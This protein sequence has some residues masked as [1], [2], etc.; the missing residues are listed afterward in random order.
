MLNFN[1]KLAIIESFPQLQR[2]DVSLGRINFQFPDSVTEKKNIVYHLHPNGNGF[3]YAGE[4][5][6]YQKDKKGMVNIREFS[7]EDLRRIIDESIQS[8]SPKTIEE[9]AIAGEAYEETWI[10][11][12]NQTLLLVEEEDMWNVYAGLNLDG[13]FNSY[14]EAIQYLDEE[15]FHRLS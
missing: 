6:G 4:L 5:A 13:T 11:R 9:E 10:N 3:V 2:N 1:E 8:L 14:G 7:A 15:G 12:D